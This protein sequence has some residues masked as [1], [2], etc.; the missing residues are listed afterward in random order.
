[1]AKEFKTFDELISVLESRNVITNNDTM[2]QLMRESYYAIVNGYKAP[3]LDTQAME[4]ENGD[5][6]RKGTKFEW[7]Y[8]LFSFDRDLRALTFK[9]LERAESIMKS[10]VVYAFCLVN[11]EPM[12]YL[13][14]SSYV[15]PQN[16]LFP[17]GYRGNKQSLHFRNLSHLMK[18]LN[19]KVSNNSNKD[20]IK[21]YVKNYGFVPLWV[22]QNDL[23]FG[24]VAHFYQLQKRSVQNKTCQIILKATGKKDKKLPYL[25]PTKLLHSFYV[26]VDFR[27]ICAHGE[28]L[29]CAKV[30]KSH[31]IGFSEMA[32]NLAL[33]LQE[34]DMRSFYKEVS[35]LVSSYGSSL[36]TVSIEALLNDMGFIKQQ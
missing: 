2:S 22:L 12:S 28:R 33:I 26:L 8:S 34:E 18:V 7:M 23:T 25:T 13:E 36:Y 21:H 19:S 31:D 10:A 3:F 35:S 16:M 17:K 27:N 20:F 5:V 4:I 14:I 30:G 6:Y 29:Y 9:Y 1:M 11:P 32:S 24:N 15:D